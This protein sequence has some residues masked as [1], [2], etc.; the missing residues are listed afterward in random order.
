MTISEE[1]KDLVKTISTHTLTWSVTFHTFQRGI[2]SCNFNSHAHVERDYQQR[3]QDFPLLI[4]THTLT[5]SVTLIGHERFKDVFA[6]QLTRSRGAWHDWLVNTPYGENFNS[7]A[8]VERDKVVGSNPAPATNFNSHAHVERDLKFVFFNFLGIFI[9]THTLTWSV[10]YLTKYFCF[11]L[12]ISTHTLTWSVTKA[13]V[14]RR[15]A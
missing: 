3:F 9:S 4:S 10:T 2:G 14:M 5:W 15:Q 11:L 6:F 1:W 13:K 12:R 7:H 8:H